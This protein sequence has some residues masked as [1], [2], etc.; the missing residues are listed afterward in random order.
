MSLNKQR[1]KKINL[2]LDHVDFWSMVGFCYR[3]LHQVLLCS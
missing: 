1:L 3:G 2:F